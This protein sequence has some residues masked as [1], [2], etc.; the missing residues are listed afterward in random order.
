M[1]KNTTLRGKALVMGD[2]LL[3]VHRLG[4]AAAAETGEYTLCF[5][6]LPAGT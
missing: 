3:D 5:G 1:Q 6:L 4:C 2:S